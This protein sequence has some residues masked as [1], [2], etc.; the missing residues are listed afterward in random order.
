MK[1]S[2]DDVPDV[3]HYLNFKPEKKAVSFRV[4]EDLPEKVEHASELLDVGVGELWEAA[5]RKLLDELKTHI[6]K[7]EHLKGVQ[8]EKSKSKKIKASS[9]FRKPG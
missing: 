2:P 8:D 1:K 7:I 3:W 9:P 6:T 5:M 4:S